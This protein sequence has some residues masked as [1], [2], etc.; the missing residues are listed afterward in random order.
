MQDDAAAGPLDDPIGDGSQWMSGPPVVVESAVPD[1]VCDA[2]V[3]LLTGDQRRRSFRGLVD[4]TLRDCHYVEVPEALAER[5]LGCV[6][7]P[8]HAHFGVDTAPVPGQPQLVY[9]YGP[10]VGFVT[11]H[12]EVTPEEVVRAADSGQPVIRG[13]LT[14]LVFLSDAADYDG[15]ELYFVSPP[16]E[17]KCARGSLIVFPATRSFLHGVRPIRGGERITLMLRRRVLPQSRA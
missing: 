6:L 13:D 11:H 16:R 9:R 12:D 2:A 1:S 4:S 14:F 5:V 15:G 3:R 17:Y 10:G 7:T 8:A